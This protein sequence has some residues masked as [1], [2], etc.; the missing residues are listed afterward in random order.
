MI[1]EMDPVAME[2]ESVPSVMSVCKVTHMLISD[3][4]YI[5]LDRSV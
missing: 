5:K 4:I 1:Q 2:M 3:A